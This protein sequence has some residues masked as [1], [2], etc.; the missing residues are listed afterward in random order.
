MSAGRP[1]SKSRSSPSS[2]AWNGWSSTPRPWP[3][4]RRSRMRRTG[5]TPSS[6]G[7]P[8]TAAS[9]WSRTAFWLARSRTNAPITP[10]A[11]WLVD[12]FPIVDEQLREIRDDLPADYYHELPKLA[13]GHLAGYPRVI[14][15]AWAYIAHTDSRFD[16]ESLRRMVVA[17]QE[18]EPLTIGELWAIAI[19][20]RILLVE[21][22]RRLA[23]QIVRSREA[24]ETADGLA[25]GL[26][27]LGPESP[28]A[29]MAALR[30][31]STSALPTAA[32]VQLFQR[33]R[34]QDPAV[35]PA[36]G[37]LEERP[38]RPGHSRRGDGP[39]RAPAP[40]HDERDRPQRDH[41][42]AA[43]LV[44]RLGAVR[45][46][47]QPR[48]RGPCAPAA[49]SATMDFATRDRYRHAVEELARGS[50]R[51]RGRRRPASAMAMADAGPL[52]DGHAT[53]ACRADR[54]P[55]YYLISDGRAGARAG[56][57][58]PRADGRSGCDAPTSGPRRSGTSGRIAVVTALV[59]A[60][61]LLLGWGGRGRRGPCSSSPSSRSAR[62]R[63][64]RSPS[65][66]ASVTYVLRP[67]TAAPARP[68]RRRADRA[69]DA[70]RRA[71]A[72]HQRGGRRGPGRR[73]RGPLPRRTARAT[74]GSPCSPTGS[75]PRPSRS[76]ATTS[77]S[78]R[79]RRP[80]TG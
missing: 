11:E 60:V 24:R 44:V 57:R 58:R 56:P 26:L 34:D 40:G 46:E 23:E 30:R 5:D 42:H 45:R 8:R 80:S 32:R 12:N 22:L 49:R 78:R 41:E 39:P 17:Y 47:R 77:S 74:S 4:P 71:D 29:A 69:A 33:L 2:S 75:T 73:P 55:G 16:P 63:I 59:L 13:E 79:R 15:L 65:S 54:D 66:I 43:H 7:S 28:E 62:R 36:L 20:L 37:W 3:P 48:R 10:A 70:R 53:V 21:N 25:D 68:R 51:H 9:C 18:V 50:G 72:P 64:W 27:G 1:G 61:P 14:G 31:L 52:A 6:P 76:P 38:R 35:T 67:E 19:S